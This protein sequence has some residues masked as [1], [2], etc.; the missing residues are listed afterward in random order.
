M[1]LTV[2]NLFDVVRSL[3]AEASNKTN[4]PARRRRYLDL[5]NRLEL[6]GPALTNRKAKSNGKDSKKRS[7]QIPSAN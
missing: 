5:A 3:R 6:N 1:R 2:A 4:S 7:R